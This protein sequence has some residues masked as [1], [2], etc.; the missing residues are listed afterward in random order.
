MTPPDLPAEQWWAALIGVLYAQLY[1]TVALDC[2][3]TMPVVGL[4]D[5]QDRIVTARVDF[6]IHAGASRLLPP[7]GPDDRAG[8]TAAS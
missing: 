1:H 3:P 4:S 6:L 8:G 5:S 7:R 2:F